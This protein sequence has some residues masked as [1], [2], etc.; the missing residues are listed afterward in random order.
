LEGS[1]RALFKG[2]IQISVWGDKKNLERPSKTIDHPGLELVPFE[3][4]SLSQHAL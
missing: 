3:H 2:A 1:G 4:V